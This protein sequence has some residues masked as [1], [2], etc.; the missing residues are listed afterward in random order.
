M[1]RPTWTAADI[2]ALAPDDKAV[3]AV[4]K[5]LK[6]KRFRAI[7]P[8]S[9]GLGWWAKC[10]GQTG[11]YEVSARPPSAGHFDTRCSCPSRKQPCK[12]ALALLIT[13]AD[14]QELP[15]LE[16]PK[17]A[18]GGDFEALLAACFADP[19]DDLARLVLADY[20]EERG[21]DDWAKLI[22]V[23]VGRAD[24]P[25]R[26]NKSA[27]GDEK[28][29]I[30]AMLEA[31]PESER[32][33]GSFSVYGR[34]SFRVERGFL[35]YAAY[36]AVLMKPSLW[37]A[38]LLAAF[39]E[40]RVESVTFESSFDFITAEAAELLRLVGVVRLTALSGRD[41][42]LRVVAAELAPGLPGSRV[43]RVEVPPASRQR[44]GELAAEPPGVQVL[45][46]HSVDLDDPPPAGLSR[47]VAARAFRGVR[48]VTVG[49]RLT[50]E[51]A[52]ILARD[53][54][55]MAAPSWLF[56]NL[57]MSAETAAILAPAGSAAALFGFAGVG[58]GAG[59]VKAW[60][61]SD[62]LRR[63][64]S[65]G[66][67]AIPPFGESEVAAIATG[68]YPLL[69]RLDIAAPRL[70]AGTAE[71]LLRS[72]CFPALA[73]LAVSGEP[74]TAL[75]SLKLRLAERSRPVG[76][77]TLGERDYR[78][79]S[80]DGA[81]GLSLSVGPGPVE[82][83]PAVAATLDW[84]RVSEVRVVGAAVTPA[85]LATLAACF[86]GG[87]DSLALDRCGLRVA[88]AK[89]L[90]E[91]LP[92]LKPR[93]LSLAGN[94]FGPVA[95]KAL[96]GCLNGVAELDLSDNGLNDQS[97]ALLPACVSVRL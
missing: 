23:Q 93:L 81:R 67:G 73:E 74:F 59:A 53:P 30:H 58:W 87:L 84:S 69:T 21:D 72:G 83:W 24:P 45:G 85:W 71:R 33:F 77:L 96:A 80:R 49:G 60:F 65:I 10:R 54:D 47:Q 63:A 41:A 51:V 4:R 17:V 15:E 52:G 46:G 38:P 66:V 28:R 27:R 1:S 25:E 88:E 82:P 7:E 56:R 50:P 2:E 64:A 31:V 78:L 37:P 11:D 79:Q 43:Q 39:R 22:R 3:L 44:C 18:A 16:A 5:L 57:A 62:W 75:D 91:L 55:L 68:R 95:L 89:A 13:L 97:R 29:L 36:S 19:D 86:P 34:N 20:L 92:A 40:G 90:A 48:V 12:H 14:A 42:A 26:G 35:Q 76:R 70:P 61:D 8:T 6:E 9:D 32:D 94:T